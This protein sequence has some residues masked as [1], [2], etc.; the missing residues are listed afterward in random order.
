MDLRDDGSGSARWGDSFQFSW[1]G[2]HDD[3]GFVSSGVGNG[4]VLERIKQLK[5]ILNNSRGCTDCL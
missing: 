2:D 5:D 3:L 1:L 4:P